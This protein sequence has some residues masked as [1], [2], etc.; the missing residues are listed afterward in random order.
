MW[1]G[2]RVAPLRDPPQE[3]DVE[4]VDRRVAGP[5]QQPAVRVG[6]VRQLVRQV[7]VLD[8]AAAAVDQGEDAEL[9][10]RVAL[11]IDLGRR[12]RPQR[13]VLAEEGR[14]GDLHQ[15]VVH[16]EVEDVPDAAVARARRAGPLRPA[17]SACR[18]GRWGW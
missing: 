3:L 6:R 13:D 16:L 1:N 8:D 11:A 7:G 4:E 2:S 5:E 10:V 17:R 18:R 9:L 15:R 12:L 14:V